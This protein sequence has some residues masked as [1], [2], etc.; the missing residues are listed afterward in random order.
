MG[1]RIG[2]GALL[3]AIA[4][5]LIG[6]ISSAVADGTLFWGIFQATSGCLIPFF[7]FIILPIGVF[8]WLRNRN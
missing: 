2:Q 3:L 7:L 1:Q 6:A 4:L 8:F 5:M